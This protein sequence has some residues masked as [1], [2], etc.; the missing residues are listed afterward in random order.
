MTDPQNLLDVL[1][2]DLCIGC[3]ACVHADPSLKLELNPEKLIYEPTGP[4]NADAAAVCPSVRV[5]F[6]ALQKNIF[7]ENAEI[8]PLGVVE[9]VML[10][11]STDLER[12]RKASSGGLIKELLREFL[13]RDDVD[14]A[15]ALAHGEGLLFF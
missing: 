9:S 3:G 1:N 6:E 12:N 14:G 5:D 7:G 8:T 11:Q 13:S 4:G 2:N 15:I 10:A